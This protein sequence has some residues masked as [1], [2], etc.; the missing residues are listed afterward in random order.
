[1]H[2]CFCATWN[3]DTQ[4]DWFEEELLLLFILFIFFTVSLFC[5]NQSVVLPQIKQIWI[6]KT[7]NFDQLAEIRNEL[8]F[9]EVI[10]DYK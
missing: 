9:N 5:P 4:L 1:M 8:M 6:P 10:V 2:C 3:A 7:L